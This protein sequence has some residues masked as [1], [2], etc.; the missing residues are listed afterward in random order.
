MGKT[1]PNNYAVICKTYYHQFHGNDLTKNY[2]FKQINTN[3]IVSYRKINIF[4]KLFDINN[5]NFDYH[6]LVT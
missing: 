3:N 1:S 4:Y 6:Y 2:H 5:N